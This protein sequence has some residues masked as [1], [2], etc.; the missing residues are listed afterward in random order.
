[1][2]NYRNPIQRWPV[3]DGYRAVERV[4]DV[5]LMPADEVPDSRVEWLW[6][7][8]IP[9]GHVTLVAGEPASGKSF[10]MA[11]LAARVSFVRPWP[12]RGDTAVIQNPKSKIENG[13]VVLVNSDDAFAEVQQPRLAAADANLTHV[14]LMRR[15]PPGSRYS[16]TS[17]V[18][19]VMNR[20]QA[21]KEAVQEAGDC[22]LVIVDDLARFVRN[23][24]GKVT[25]A[26]LLLAIDGLR[27]I[28]GECDVAVV[29]VWR[30]ERTGRTAARMLENLLPS[31]AMA[32]LVGND[33][34]RPRL[35][36]AVALRCHFGPLPGPMAFHIEDHSVVWESPPDTVPADVMAAFVRKSERRLERE[37]AGRWALERLADGPVE[38]NT[39]F[40]DGEAFGFSPRTLRRAL[41]DLGLKPK[42]QGNDG[43]WCW[44][45]KAE[46]KR[47]KSEEREQEECQRVEVVGSPS[48][49]SGDGTAWEGHP[50][51]PSEDG[52]LATNEEAVR[53]ATTLSPASS[54][55]ERENCAN[56]P[57]TAATADGTRSVPATLVEDGQLATNE[58]AVRAATTLTPSLSEPESEDYPPSLAEFPITDA[59]TCDNDRI[60]I[61]VLR[62]SSPGAELSA[63]DAAPP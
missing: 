49:E 26:D 25:R 14:G 50:P 15:L 47:Q 20:L 35:R 45:L 58:E 23:G 10:W 42:K 28:A 43:P 24:L 29:V 2:S 48:A 55:K 56:S 12:Y 13:A 63:V 3:R 31:A 60:T 16:Q 6:P 39:L 61:V 11:D 27:C 19:P 51:M 21:V 22:K 9:V 38:A 32:W 44:A 5:A 18:G 33:P 52:Q 8:V 59:S 53:A 34:Y 36:W 30:L 40:D 37:Q 57:V 7:G 54:Q 41:G 1:M 4:S 62:P 17:L 46:G